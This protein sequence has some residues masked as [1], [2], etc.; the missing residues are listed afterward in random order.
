MNRFNVIT[1]ILISTRLFAG[2]CNTWSYTNSV[3]PEIPPITSG[4]YYAISKHNTYTN[5]EPMVTGN[6]FEY[7]NWHNDLWYN[8]H[9]I[10]CSIM[11]IVPQI[12][13]DFVFDDYVVTNCYR[14][15]LN[16]SVTERTQFYTSDVNYT[17]LKG[18]RSDGTLKWERDKIGST[19]IYC[20]NSSGITIIKRVNDPQ[21]CN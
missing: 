1:I 18:Y 5:G 16:C 12:Q 14:I 3:T 13:Y 8:T 11:D 10:S 6:A 17:D 21:Y 7:T 15:T 9:W 2:V 20:Y 4:K 19:D